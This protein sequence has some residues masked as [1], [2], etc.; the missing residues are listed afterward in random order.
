MITNLS[1]FRQGAAGSLSAR[2]K[3]HEDCRYPAR[4]DKLPVAPTILSP[5]ALDFRSL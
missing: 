2:V 4:A 5:L 3:P 1:F